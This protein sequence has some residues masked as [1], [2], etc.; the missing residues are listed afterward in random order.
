MSG[1]GRHGATRAVLFSAVMLLGGAPAL[2]LAYTV[3]P[4]DTLSEIAAEQ[5][6]SLAELVAVN[7]ISDP[8]R[9]FAGQELTIPGQ[10]GGSSMYVVRSGDTLGAIAEGHGVTVAALLLANPGIGNA[11]MIVE[12]QSLVMP[13]PVRAMDAD[14]TVG[15]LLASEARRAG[16]DPA[17]VQALAWQESGWR[18]DAVS[19]AGAVGVLQLLPETAAWIASDIVGEP[20]DTVGSARDNVRAGVALLSW[21]AARAN[22][23]ELMLAWYYQGQGSVAANGVFPSTWRYI[24]NVQALRAYIARYG[25]PPPP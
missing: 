16:L 6:V 8:D 4:G 20:L 2:A 15:A 10:A 5:G 7:G 24:A 14:V 19:D 18:Q 25:A 17:L 11:D 12:G 21:L 3:Q 23:E 22:S 13:P 1:L 9:V